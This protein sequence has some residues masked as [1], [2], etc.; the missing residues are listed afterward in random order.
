MTNNCSKCGNC[1]KE[2]DCIPHGVKTPNYCISDT[3]ACPEPAPCTE[4]FD[5]NCVIY[6]GQGNE[7]LDINTG[8]T[9]QNIIDNIA[10]KLESILCIGCVEL[11][12][13]SNNASNIVLSPT[14]TWS[15]VTNAI[16]YDLY[17]G[18]DETLVSTQDPSVKV[19]SNQLVTSYTVPSILN[20]STDYYWKVVPKTSLGD[21][22]NCSVYKFTTESKDCINPIQYVLEQNLKFSCSYDLSEAT[23]ELS[24]LDQNCL[25]QIVINVSGVNYTFEVTTPSFDANA[26]VNYLNTLNIGTAQLSGSSI[27]ITGIKSYGNI[28]FYINPSCI[29]EIGSNIIILQPEC[30]EFE[31]I[32]SN[33]QDA[34]ETGIFISAAECDYCCPDCDTT[35]RYILTGLTEDYLSFISSFYDGQN[36][37]LAPCCLNTQLS[38]RGYVTLKDLFVGPTDVNEFVRA[39]E[40]KAKVEVNIAE[41]SYSPINIPFPPNC[42]CGTD[43]QDCVNS[44]KSLFP[45]LWNKILGETGIIEESTISNTTTLCIVKNIIESIEYL[46]EQERSEILLA[47]LNIGIVVEC[48]DQGMIITSVAGYADYIKSILE[49]QD[50]PCDCVNV[51]FTNTLPKETGSDITITYIDCQYGYVINTLSP[52]QSAYAC[53]VNNSWSTDPNIDIVIEG[54]CNDPLACVNVSFSLNGEV[55][56]AEVQ[57]VPCNGGDIATV[58]LDSFHTPSTNVCAVDN[59]WN[60]VRGVD[61]EKL[62]DCELAKNKP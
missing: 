45:T 42:P 15:P 46:S 23:K 39:K 48:T 56:A 3:P 24:E 53:V 18:N 2:C 29:G 37:C 11:V 58:L 14:L 32:I 59:S 50:N 28:T 17:F 5:S 33:L 40:V 44:L 6:T 22:Q 19:I 34:L 61:Y 9:V 1:Q 10:E 8:D 35:N 62:G 13:P 4:T 16:G 27:I 20:I 52:E 51:T 54:S 7:C 36:Y 38:L 26:Y 43:F 30:S 47:I 31:S 25:Q 41:P 60:V 49:T 55:D 21:A 12:I 57:Y